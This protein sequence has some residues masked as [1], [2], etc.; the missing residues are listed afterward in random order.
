MMGFSAAVA[1]SFNN[2]INPTPNSASSLSVRFCGAG[3]LG[4]MCKTQ[5]IEFHYT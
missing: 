5:P 1:A 2:K 3:Y 4:V